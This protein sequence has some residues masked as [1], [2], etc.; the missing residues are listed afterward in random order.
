MAL[1]SGNLE[2]SPAFER[3]EAL[4]ASGFLDAFSTRFVS[5]RSG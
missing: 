3:L 4:F 5:Y 2:M 1:P